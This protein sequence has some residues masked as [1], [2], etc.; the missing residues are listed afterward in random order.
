[1]LDVSTGSKGRRRSCEIGG[2][3]ELASLTPTGFHEALEAFANVV[4]LCAAAAWR[5]PRRG[6]KFALR[7]GGRRF[8]P[9][10][11]PF[12]ARGQVISAALQGLWA[13]EPQ[14]AASRRGASAPAEESPSQASTDVPARW[15]R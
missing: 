13:L 1:M 11:A 2:R 5:G 4:I 14:R 8:A 6:T 3:K 7:G 15:R 9:R 12:S 10:R